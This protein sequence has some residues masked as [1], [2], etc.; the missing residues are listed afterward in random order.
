MLH[1]LAG[2][3]IFIGRW[4]GD[5]YSVIGIH[6]RLEAGSNLSERY[7]TMDEG[8]EV[9]IAMRPPRHMNDPEY[10]KGPQGPSKI[11]LD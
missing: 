8:G 7:P 3:C 1:C 5:W 6:F 10:G 9:V 4:R 11:L 2:E